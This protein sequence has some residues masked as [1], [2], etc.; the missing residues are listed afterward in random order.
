[1]QERVFRYTLKGCRFVLSDSP[2]WLW[3]LLGKDHTGNIGLSE[4]G[5]DSGMKSVLLGSPLCSVYNSLDIPQ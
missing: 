2:V 1:M 5:L 3:D 4:L